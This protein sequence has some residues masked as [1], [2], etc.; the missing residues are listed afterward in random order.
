VEEDSVRLNKAGYPRV[1]WNNMGFSPS[2][3][4]EKGAKG[5]SFD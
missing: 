4:E 5:V 1:E 2:L 3:R